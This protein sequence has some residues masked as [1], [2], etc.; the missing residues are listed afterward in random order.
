[1]THVQGVKCVLS[2]PGRRLHF[3]A[4][5]SWVTSEDGLGSVHASPA[6]GRPLRRLIAPFSSLKNITKHVLLCN[7]PIFSR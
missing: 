2:A 3:P 1:M 4:T 7:Q 5:R 6:R